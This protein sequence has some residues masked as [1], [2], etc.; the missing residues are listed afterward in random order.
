MHFENYENHGNLII[1]R[2]NHENQENLEII[3]RI[4]KKMKIINFHEIIIN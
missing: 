4:T 3:M 2:E 1:S